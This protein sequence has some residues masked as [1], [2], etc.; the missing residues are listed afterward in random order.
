[1]QILYDK[2]IEINEIQRLYDKI[3]SINLSILSFSNGNLFFLFWLE[4]VSFLFI[5]RK[6]EK[7]LNNL[8]FGIETLSLFFLGSK[9][10]YDANDDDNDD[11]A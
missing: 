10:Y 1:M 9:Y 8:H 7:R 3:Q 5:A 4:I 11:D 2:I 6:E